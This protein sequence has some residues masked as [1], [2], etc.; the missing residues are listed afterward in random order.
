MQEWFANLANSF[1]KT[2]I[3]S[4]RWQLFLKGFGVTIRVA[5]LALLMGIVIGILVAIV[6]TKH[7]SRKKNAHGFG[8]VI[9]NILNVICQVYLTVIRGTP[10]MVQLMIVYFVIFASS[11]NSVGV[12]T[13]AFGINSGAYVAE[14]VRGG[15]MSVDAGQMEAGRSLGMNYTQTMRRIIIPQ[16]IKN[17][18]PALGNEMITLL[19]DTSLMTVTGAKDLMKAAQT[20]TAVTYQPFMPYI[21]VAVIYLVCVMVLS[22]LLAIF[23]RRMRNSDRR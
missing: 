3:T 16:A 8:N 12:A 5:L 11:R 1:T 4:D 20:V 17:I 14:I 7:D 9:L 10:M 23:E 6:R 13:L 18:L 19:K 22:K 2:F 21:S 15:I